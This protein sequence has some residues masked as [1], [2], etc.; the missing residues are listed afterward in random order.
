LDAAAEDAGTAFAVCAP[1]TAAL[2]ARNNI[3][4]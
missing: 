3:N 4:P 1:A 2:S